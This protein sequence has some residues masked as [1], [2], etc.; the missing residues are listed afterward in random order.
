MSQSSQILE[1]SSLS[2]FLIIV[3][4]IVTIDS[5]LLLFIS[6]FRMFNFA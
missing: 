1:L 6:T 5:D 3:S 4:E 2:V